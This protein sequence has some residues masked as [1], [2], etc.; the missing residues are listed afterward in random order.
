MRLPFRQLMHEAMN[1]PQ[2]TPQMPGHDL[3]DRELE[4]ANS[5]EHAI[6]TGSLAPMLRTFGMGG[7]ATLL[8][9]VSTQNRG[10]AA[11]LLFSK[12]ENDVREG[13][14]IIAME[15]RQQ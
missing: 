14:H 12:N 1:E 5:L 2:S 9:G 10:Q 7:I 6:S 15:H 11:R 13:L 4:M 3:D 8:R